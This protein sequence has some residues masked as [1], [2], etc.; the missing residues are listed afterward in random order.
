MIVP[1][2]ANAYK[3]SHDGEI[4]ITDGFFPLLTPRLL[5]RVCAPDLLDMV[6]HMLVMAVEGGRHEP[7]GPT[8]PNPVRTAA[9]CPLPRPLGV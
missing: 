7:E 6:A 3:R 4:A 2:A 1:T 9:T 5:L 8:T